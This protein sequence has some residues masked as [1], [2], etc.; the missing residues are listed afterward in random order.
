MS[1]YENEGRYY[2]SIGIGCTGGRHRSVFIAEAL[3]RHIKKMGYD[4]ALRHRDLERVQV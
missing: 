4:T 1:Q 3:E 2:L